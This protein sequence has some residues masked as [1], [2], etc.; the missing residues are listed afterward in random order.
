MHLLSTLQEAAYMLCTVSHCCLIL[1]KTL[2]KGLK[3][4]STGLADLT[5]DWV[6]GCASSDAH[7]KVVTVSLPCLRLRCHTLAIL[8][9]LPAT[10]ACSDLQGRLPVGHGRLW[11]SP[12]SRQERK[13]WC[14]SGEI[15]GLVQI[16][17]TEGSW[18]RV[19]EV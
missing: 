3:R 5:D 13:L 8:L 2:L 18:G 16:W 1:S 9:Q 7:L 6:G 12:G 11:I 10:V 17:E 15:R 4:L 19:R 14:G